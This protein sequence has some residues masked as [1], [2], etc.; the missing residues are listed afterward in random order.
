MLCAETVARSWIPLRLNDFVINNK[1]DKKMKPANKP[2]I[3]VTVT[4]DVKPEWVPG[5]F[6][7]PQDFADVIVRDAKHSLG[8]YDPTLVETKIE[9]RGPESLQQWKKELGSLM[10]E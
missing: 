6:Y 2:R 1:K 8:A 7:D 9:R 5:M 10:A 4:I 3:R